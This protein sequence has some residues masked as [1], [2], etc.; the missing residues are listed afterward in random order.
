MEVKEIQSI[1]DMLENSTLHKLQLKI[2]DMELTL[3][4]E[5]A[6]TV[7]LSQVLP[8]AAPV[9]QQPMAPAAPAPVA[10]APAPVSN[11]TLVK[12]PLV[13]IFY[14][15]SSPEAAPYV[16]VGSTVKKGDVVCIVEAMKIMNEVKAPKDGVIKEIHLENGELVEFDQVLM[17]IGE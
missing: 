2:K 15:S 16:S 13:G 10:A 7:Q 1:I 12:S 3:E 17:E 14:A 4:K 5:T 6:P 8:A 11:G 9:A